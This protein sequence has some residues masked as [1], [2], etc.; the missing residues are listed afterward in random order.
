MKVSRHLIAAGTGGL[1]A[2]LLLALA[3]W[4]ASGVRSPR[5]MAAEAAP[6]AASHITVA[7]ERRTLVEPTT[8]RG[9]VVPGP[10]TPVRLPTAALGAD[11][12]VTHV[13]VREGTAMREGQVLVEV[14]GLPVLALALPFPLYRDLAGGDSGRDVVEV[15]KALGRLGYQVK[16]SGEFDSR[17]QSRLREWFRAM[18]YQPQT[19]DEQAVLAAQQAVSTAE[20]AL[21]GPRTD[22]DER[23]EVLEERVAQAKAALA[24]AQLAAGPMLRRDS[25]VQVPATTAEVTEVPVRVGMVLDDPDKSILVRLDGT[26]P[27][28]VALATKE[29]ADLLSVGQ[30]AEVLDEVAGVRGRVTVAA[31][32]DQVEEDDAGG[33]GYRVVFSFDD[34]PIEAN[35]R[36]VRIDV[37]RDDGQEPTLA[38]P[39]AAIYQHADGSVFVT[40]L[41]GDTVRDIA[42]ETGQIAGGWVAVD[43]VES[44]ELVEG[45]SVVVGWE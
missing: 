24:R 42:V 18:G 9:Q 8:L 36:S 28:V 6:P 22:T 17:T 43:P 30:S 40:V 27:Q 25:V 7:A 26:G 16:V 29:Q 19:G 44:G 38:V 37:D 45:T 15:Q 4:A 2:T 21:R 5:Q 12:V 3:V 10:S 31:V 33:V 14:S 39:V 1:V 41:V 20:E 11:A 23:T 34:E 13:P 35:G 32:G